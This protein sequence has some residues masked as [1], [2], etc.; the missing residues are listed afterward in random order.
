M[1][2]SQASD[3]DAAHGGNGLT[4][5]MEITSIIDR[6]VLSGRFELDDLA[7]D[8]VPLGTIPAEARVNIGRISIFRQFE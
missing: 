2:F 8:L 7:V 1:G 5:T 4:F 3:I 6:L